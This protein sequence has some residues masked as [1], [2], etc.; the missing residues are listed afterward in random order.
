MNKEYVSDKICKTRQIIKKI[1]PS[2][3]R[4][5][6]SLERNN[7]RIKKRIN[8]NISKAIN[9]QVGKKVL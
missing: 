6:S 5:E 3:Y 1:I 2:H 4:R 7:F 9:K 8:S